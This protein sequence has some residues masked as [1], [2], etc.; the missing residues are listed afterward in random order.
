MHRHPNPNCPIGGNIQEALDCAFD[1]AQ[2][3]MEKAL[4]RFSVA[5]ILE[6]IRGENT[7]TIMGEI[8]HHD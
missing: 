3:A 6:N 2:A 4:E 8:D 7:P 5:N 1:D